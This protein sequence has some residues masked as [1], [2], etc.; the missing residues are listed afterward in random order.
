MPR[1]DLI[2]EALYN[3]YIR[4]TEKVSAHVVGIELEYPIVNL[5][6]QTISAAGE[7]T[8]PV[9]FDVVHRLAED[10]TEKFGFADIMRDDNGEIYN[11]ADPL[12]GDAISFDC[13]YN[14]L[15]FSFGA[16]KDITEVDKRFRK[17]YPYIQHKL[18][19][20]GHTLTGM[21]INP[22]YRV[23]RIEPVAN[24][25]YRMLLRHLR[26]YVDHGNAIQF[27]DYPHFG[28]FSC[29]SQVQLDAER[30]DLVHTLNTFT[31]LEPIKA[32]LFANSRFD[33]DEHHRFAVSRDYLWRQSM[34]G[35]NPH[36]VDDYN[37]RLHSIDEVI[38]YIESMSLYCTERDGKYINFPPILLDDYF[39]RE[40]VTGTYWSNEYNE[41]REITFRPEISDID[42]LRSFKF[43]DL[44]FRG[45]IEFRSV[46]EQPVSDAFSVA[47][48]HAGLKRRVGELS[49]LLDGDREIYQQGYSVGELRRMFV[50][51]DIPGFLDRSHASD[52][53]IRILDLA[54]DGLRERGFGE[55]KYLQPLYR[56][57]ELFTNP[58]REEI[59]SLDEGA[60]IRD[61]L[62]DRSLME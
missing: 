38:S 43:N 7:I 52:M 50:M 24:G 55:G 59:H 20:S 35:I 25:R 13:S 21:G 34:H 17:F 36:N 6:S 2:R 29:A 9:D 47:A 60:S 19:E 56:R 26:S 40:S 44:T 37:T 14:T 57:A 15:E 5:N 12:T 3:K 16:A 53:M 11:A 33:A 8:A 23:N 61:I 51:R 39:E 41:L 10:F 54:E 22:G 45:T 31:K 28:L 30:N 62:K 48:F 32:L 27:H 1:R 49:E 46:C 4:P 42:Y 58:A 18:A